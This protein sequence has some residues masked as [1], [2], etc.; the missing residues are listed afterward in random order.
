MDKQHIID[1]IRRTSKDGK[2][3]GQK[4]FFTET[5][6]RVHEW[7][8]KYWAKWGDALI[9]AGFGENEWQV[10]YD[11]ADIFENLVDLT[12]RLGRYPTKAEMQ[13]ERRRNITFPSPH[14][15]RRLGSKKQIIK[16]LIDYCQQVGS[17]DVLAILREIPIVGESEE[18]IEHDDSKPQ[19]G[20][21]YLLASAKNTRSVTRKQLL[22]EHP[23]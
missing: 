8:G 13:L 17:E 3:I 12:K 16:K 11:E 10:A 14:P 2:A 21:V 9:E 6:I 22:A 18:P 15:I 4:L 20:Y 7:H 19:L 23:S 1:E 5:G